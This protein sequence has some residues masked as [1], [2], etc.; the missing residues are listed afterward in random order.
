LQ[1][2]TKPNQTT[3]NTHQTQIE[4]KRKKEKLHYKKRKIMVVTAQIFSP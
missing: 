4:I 3:N 2:N 1:E